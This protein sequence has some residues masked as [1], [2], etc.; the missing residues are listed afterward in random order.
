MDRALGLIE[1]LRTRASKLTKNQK[2]AVG[3]VSA[4]IFYKFIRNTFRTVKNLNG[5]IVF[6]TG[7]ANGIGKQVA[8]LMAREGAKVAVADIDKNKADEVVNELLSEKLQAIAI[9]CDVTSLESVQRAATTVRNHLGD[10]TILI[11]N[12]G[13]I[14]GKPITDIPIANVERTF[15]VNVISHF[16][17]IQEFLPSMLAKN[18]GHIVTIAS[19]A[20]HVG[21]SRQTDYSASKHAAV[22]LDESLRNELRS[23]GS[24][25]KTTCINP[26]YIDTGMFKGVSSQIPLLKEAYVSKRIVQA[27]KNEEKVV[28]LPRMLSITHMFR[29]FLSVENFDWVMELTGANRSME[30]FTGRT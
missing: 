13:I 17:T 21:I 10:P 30:T 29:A 8:I 16:Y 12:A 23:M 19:L 4:Y 15:K 27:I 20:G 5:Q 2:V 22:G 18:E 26:F 28:I 9:H 1:T 25:V 11:N 24:N 7:A 6:I 3:V 14:S